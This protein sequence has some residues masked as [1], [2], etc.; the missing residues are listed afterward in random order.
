MAATEEIAINAATVAIIEMMVDVVVTIRRKSKVDTVEIV[1]VVV[2][3][4]GIVEATAVIGEA[5]GEEATAA[6]SETSTAGGSAT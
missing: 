6:E 2:T 1:A 5:E 3:A 4:V